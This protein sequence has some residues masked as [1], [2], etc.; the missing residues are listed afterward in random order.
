MEVI[1]MKKLLLNITFVALAL[2]SHGYAMQPESEHKSTSAACV[3]AIDEETPQKAPQ[4]PSRI[5][6]A[7]MVGLGTAT[8][9]ALTGILASQASISDILFPA[10]AE[11]ASDDCWR[12][13]DDAHA[14]V[15]NLYF[16][17][18]CILGAIASGLVAGGTTYAVKDKVV[19]LYKKIKSLLTSNTLTK[20]Q[21]QKL[22]ILAQQQP[23]IIVSSIEQVAEAINAAQFYDDTIAN[24]LYKTMLANAITKRAQEAHTAVARSEELPEQPG[25]DI[26]NLLLDS[27]YRPN[28]LTQQQEIPLEEISLVDSF[29]ND[30]MRTQSSKPTSVNNLKSLIKTANVNHFPSVELISWLRQI[31]EQLKQKEIM[32]RLLRPNLTDQKLIEAM[33]DAVLAKNPDAFAI[34]SATSSPVIEVPV[35]QQQSPAAPAVSAPVSSTTSATVSS[36]A[37]SQSAAVA[38]PAPTVAAP[39]IEDE[40][41]QEQV[42]QETLQEASQLST[43]QQQALA[44]VLPALQVLGPLCNSN[45]QIITIKKTVRNKNLLQQID[46]LQETLQRNPQNN[47]ARKQL[48]KLIKNLETEKQNN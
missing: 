15:N 37:A 14:R 44:R 7:L 1:F 45:A 21:N 10:A 6:P 19:A 8:S 29:L 35:V 25:L 9:L 20:E 5:K 24:S 34:V 36:Q 46:A 47:Q 43:E 42:E 32:Y 11:Q 27:P 30:D 17:H 33:N 28:K 41:K 39:V 38:N 23:A 2:G 40:K 31:I 18:R 13:C 16:A 3:A 12:N 4:Q 26:D 48:Q 22:A